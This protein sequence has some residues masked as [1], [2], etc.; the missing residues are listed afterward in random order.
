MFNV[1]SLTVLA[2]DD[3][4]GEIAYA[5]VNDDGSTAGAIGDFSIDTA[6]GE[7]TVATAPTYDMANPA[8]NIRELTV[9]ARDTSVSAIGDRVST[10]DITILVTPMSSLTLQS[11]AGLTITVDESDDAPIDITTISIADMGATPAVMDPYSIL[12]G[13][14]G[15][16]VDSGGVIRA[17]VDYEALSQEQ[18]ESGISLIVRGRD[19][20]GADGIIILALTIT[21]ID[22]EAPTFVSF[23]ASAAIAPGFRT[24]QGGELVI[25]AADD[26]GNELG[27]AFLNTN[28]TTTDA[29]GDFTIDYET[30]VIGV[31]NLPSYSETDEAANSR[32]L[33]VQARDRSS[34]AIGDRD[35]SE[36]IVIEILPIIDADNDGFIEIDNF[37]ELYNIRYNLEGTGYKTS[38]E[39]TEAVGGCPNYQCEGYEL[40]RSL[41]FTNGSQYVA[42]GI[43]TNWRP[44]N[45]DPDLATND[46]WEPI[47][48]CNAD[49]DGDFNPCGD[50]DDA[51]FTAV[52]VGNGYTISGLYARGDGAVGLFG[53]TGESASIRGVGVIDGN[54]Y[55]RGSDDSVGGLVGLNGGTISASY[56]TI[57]VD[58]GS[59]SDSVGGLVGRNEGSVIASYSIGV[60]DGGSGGFDAVGGLVGRNGGSVIASYAVGAVNGG[61]DSSDIVGGL[62]GQNDDGGSII[63]SY[64]VGAVEGGSGN[65]DRVGGLVSVNG[66]RGLIIASYGFGDTN[67][68]IDSVSRSDDA[69]P[70]IYSPAVITAETSSTVLA[71]RWDEAAWVFGDN[72][73]YPAVAWVTGYDSDAG[74][75]SCISSAL[76][77]AAACGDP[78]PGQHDGDSDGTQDSVLAASDAAPTATA[79]TFD[80]DVM[81]DAHSESGVIAYRLYRGASPN[82]SS[83]EYIVEIAVDPDNPPANY[84][85]TDTNPFDGANHYAVSAV[86]AAG[87]GIRSSLSDG[88][89]LP[90]VD[91]D[92]DGLIEINTLEEL[93]NIRHN[94]NGTNYKTSSTANENSNGCPSAGCNGYELM[95][96]LDFDN[97]AHYESAMVN[98]DWRPDNPNLD[99]AGNAGWEPIGAADEPFAAIFEGNGNTITGLYTRRSGEIG[100]FGA[101]DE[102]ANIRNIGLIGGGSYG[103]GDIGFLVGQNNG[104]IIAGYAT[105]EVNGGNSTDAVGGLVG[106]NEGSG[107]II[108]SYATG[109]VDGIG[110]NGNNVGGLVG[111]NKGSIAASY[112]IGDADGGA[113]ADRVGGLVGSSSNSGVIVA[114]YAVGDANGG[115]N[116]RNS[117]R[118]G[119]LVGSNNGVI[120]AGYAVGEA[121]GGDGNGD[122]VG[123]LVGLN[124][125][126][127]SIAAAYATGVAD[128]GGGF[129]NYV[130]ALVGVND[131]ATIAS[132]GFGVLMGRM[133]LG[134]SNF[135]NRSDDV[136]PSIHSP[137]VL[138]MV[139][140]STMPEN[141]WNGIA[142][143]FGDDQR[144]PVV[145]WVT[146]YDSDI[147]SPLCDPAALPSTA[148]CGV[149]IPG[150]YDGDGDGMQDLAPAAPV[151][152]TINAATASD[153]TITW[154]AVGGPEITA[155]RLYRNAA[156]G[157][158]ALA[159][160]PFAEIAVDPDNPPA[161]YTYTD[162][163]PFDGANHYAVSAVNAA[164]EGERSSTVNGMT[165]P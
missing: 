10:V 50:G 57:D 161:N 159:N 37:D 142:W 123:G 118:V 12:S 20:S 104:S 153:I 112:A 44:D 84:T 65:S 162:T 76:P 155:Y 53:L 82:S 45:A 107:S 127:A 16:L 119:G 102:S 156:E 98:S 55:G 81:W 33:V 34:G 163:N 165:T 38:L 158:P 39:E 13:P 134:N 51:P 129:D 41:D 28:G 40:T 139:N 88:V 43:N 95:R 68:E 117:D 120:V 106:A 80:I 8:A 97:A 133:K 83:P 9:Q 19:S 58:G 105:G 87:I 157:D 2:I 11:N 54:S 149:P 67:G 116:A 78:I 125:F 164:G 56:A 113:L 60:A 71:N 143:S 26:I 27:Y 101:T 128:G 108:A 46:G 17:T 93:N 36:T 131:G 160:R 75:F 152:P 141:R 130:G 122:Y 86:N 72:R 79:N 30:G 31:A 64:S 148:A 70:S 62:V 85:Y 103:N 22:D 21:D 124:G 154:T 14:D 146:G 47:G 91:A 29:I 109:D 121:N 114:G 73:R 136:D 90:P 69:N 151:A 145:N 135:V 6:T 100:L 144:Y 66:N 15:F 92:G 77:P 35:A 49:I 111:F 140:S 52:F 25:E 7:I 4:G 89:S 132:Y 137:A 24:F 96:S 61:A 115:N 59:F 18:Q 42:R 5:F 32:A 99:M 110:G 126:D 48:S 3:L 150:Q 23:P 147:G 1:D 74:A 94:L 138:N 63:A